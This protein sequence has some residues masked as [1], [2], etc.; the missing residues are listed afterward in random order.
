MTT[1]NIKKALIDRNLNITKL[2]QITGF[3][4]VYLSNVIN[5]HFEGPK[6][7]K[8]IAEALDQNFNDL[9]GN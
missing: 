9:W 2:A 3:S 5:G 7:R 4:R 8:A 1:K 6:A